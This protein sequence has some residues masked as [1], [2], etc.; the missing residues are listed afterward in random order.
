MTDTLNL[1]PCPFCGGEV[2]IKQHKIEAKE[3]A[4]NWLIQCPECNVSMSLPADD[5]YGRIPMTEEEAIAKWNTRK[6][7]YTVIDVN[8]PGDFITFKSL[9]NTADRFHINLRSRYYT[10]CCHCGHKFTGEDHMYVAKVKNSADLYVCED[11]AKLF[12]GRKNHD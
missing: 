5:Y 9:S 3:R 1:K 6:R 2:E 8:Y 4:W 11:C 12:N 10:R 7:K